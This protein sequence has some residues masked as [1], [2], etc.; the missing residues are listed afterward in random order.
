MPTLDKT[1][2]GLTP[3]FIGGGAGPLFLIV[4]CYTEI[5]QMKLF[6]HSSVVIMEKNS[7]V[8]FL[9]ASVF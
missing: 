1:R 3:I 4:A 8:Q 5:Q 2:L 6:Q 9:P 7:L